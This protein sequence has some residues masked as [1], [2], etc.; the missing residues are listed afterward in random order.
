MNNDILPLFR[1]Q[2]RGWPFAKAMSGSLL[3]TLV[4]GLLPGPSAAADQQVAIS[5]VDDRANWV[6][7]PPPKPKPVQADR[8]SVAPKPAEATKPT[9]AAKPVE[10]AKPP[11]AVKPVETAKPL[12]AGKPVEAAKPADVPRVAN[13]AE[14]GIELLGFLF[15]GNQAISS[16]EL[17]QA[18]AGQLGM[19]SNM[20]EFEKIA[21][22]V[23]RYYRQRGILARAD[24][25]QQELSAGVLRVNIT[26]AKFGGAVMDDPGG[27]LKASDHLV[28][29]IERQ[30]PVG[31]T[32]NLKGWK[33]PPCW[34]LN[35]RA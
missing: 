22:E 34:P 2:P 26:E 3:A 28:R 5:A 14:V 13:Q 6:Q 31:Q 24:L 23:T 9:E 11:E 29:L 4:V 7:F 8:D 25:P 12:E 27:A 30:Q 17:G 1:P 19:K 32:I 35:C 20:A 16:T 18:L 15:V 21:E 10:A 33:T